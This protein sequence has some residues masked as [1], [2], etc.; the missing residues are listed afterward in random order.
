M[1][2]NCGRLD[3]ENQLLVLFL[4][5]RPMYSNHSWVVLAKD[6]YNCEA[7]PCLPEKGLSDPFLY[8]T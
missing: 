5:S 7:V 4:F 8:A 6:C 1:L 2:L 3:Y